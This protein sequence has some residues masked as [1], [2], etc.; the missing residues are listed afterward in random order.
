MITTESITAGCRFYIG[1]GVLFGP[2]FL[3]I[4]WGVCGD[5]NAKQVPYLGL[6]MVG[7]YAHLLQHPEQVFE[8]LD[9]SVPSALAATLQ[10]QVVALWAVATVWLLFR[11]VWLHRSTPASAV[12][13][14][15][16]LP[17]QHN[18]ERAIVAMAEDEVQLYRSATATAAA[19][20]PAVRESPVDSSEQP[21][22][23]T[24]S[25]GL[26]GPQCRGGEPSVAACGTASPPADCGEAE[27]PPVATAAVLASPVPPPPTTAVPAASAPLP[28]TS[29]TK[30]PAPTL[31]N[32]S[33]DVSAAYEYIGA[34]SHPGA[35]VAAATGFTLRLH[36]HGSCEDSCY[37]EP[38]PS[39]LLVLLQVVQYYS[40]VILSMSVALAFVHGLVWCSCGY[41]S[42][43]AAVLISCLAMQLCLRGRG[44]CGVITMVP[45]A[46]MPLWCL[47]RRGEYTVLQFLESICHCDV[48]CGAHSL[49][50]ASPVATSRRFAVFR[51]QSGSWPC[52][53]NELLAA[54][55][56]MVSVPQSVLQVR[57]W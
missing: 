22:L 53:V 35:D 25:T 8:A 4:C 31:P 54:K 39:R 45:V 28:T 23:A 9:A 2:A 19:A 29:R 3:G 44:F 14:L 40:E 7:S 49:Y 33:P 41:T 34:E 18:V 32:R 36:P 20:S 5:D 42:H 6:D 16:R 21:V 38:P 10:L 51:R 47:W 17:L 56:L 13:M 26:V 48:A 57:Y 1:Y 43:V 11:A 50:K 55:G 46:V 37:H 15:R 12:R 52:N 30:V 24:A 27:N